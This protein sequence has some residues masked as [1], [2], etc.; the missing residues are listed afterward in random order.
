VADAA[1]RL[2]RVAGASMPLWRGFCRTTGSE[3]S[4]D[5]LGSSIWA[6]VSA[7]GTSGES[8][9]T[10]TPVGAAFRVGGVVPPAI[11]CAGENPVHPWTSDGGALDVL[12]F[13]N[14][15]LWNFDSVTMSCVADALRSWCSVNLFFD[16]WV[17]FGRTTSVAG[18][19]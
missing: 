19:A 7:G 3:D 5:R 8:L 16:G 17:C 12:T 1:V 11:S 13:L 2:L 4:G 9:A 6:D 14:A 15:S 18:G 10:A